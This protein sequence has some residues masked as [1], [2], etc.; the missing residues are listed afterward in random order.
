MENGHGFVAR[1]QATQR[2]FELGN[3]FA[4]F[5]ALREISYLARMENGHGF[6]ARRQV[7]PRFS[8]FSVPL[9]LW[10]F[11]GIALMECWYY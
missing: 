11:L 2:F 7:T 6:V 4:F 8:F 10:E 3:Y 5:A 1:R 9:C